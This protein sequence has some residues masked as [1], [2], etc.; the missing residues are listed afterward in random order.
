MRCCSYVLQAGYSVIATNERLRLIRTNGR[1][2]GEVLVWIETMR[3]LYNSKGFYHY[4]QNGVSMPCLG[5][6]FT[7]AQD[8]LEMP[9]EFNDFYFGLVDA[10]YPRLGHNFL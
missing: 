10:V 2:Y 8:L 4:A 9:V 3:A 5:N 1:L 6:R 7:L